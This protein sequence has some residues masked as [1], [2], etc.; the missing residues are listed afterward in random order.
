MSVIDEL[1]D[2]FGGHWDGPEHRLH[3]LVKHDQ[4]RLKVDVVRRGDEYLC[5]VFDSGECLA[6][7]RAATAT[8]AVRSAF[9]SATNLDH[10]GTS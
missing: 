10:T 4:R 6:T 2:E 9:E 1:A 7:T 8:E 5:S 3:G